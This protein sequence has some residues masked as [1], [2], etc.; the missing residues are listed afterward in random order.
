M[1]RSPT[2]SPRPRAPAGR[3]RC[4][5]GCGE[6]IRAA[7]ASD[8][9][10]Q[11]AGREE[12]EG[13]LRQ[14]D[15]QVKDLKAQEAGLLRDRRK[16]KDEKEDLERQKERMR[17]EIR[18][19]ERADA[20]QRARQRAEEILRRAYESYQEQLRR[21]EEDHGTQTRQL[22]D[23]LKRVRAQL[24]EAQ[25]KSATGSRQ[26]EGLARQDLFGEETPAPLPRRPD[27]GDPGGQARA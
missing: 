4:A 7:F 9:E 6:E 15:S 8:L 1:R 10:A 24:E 16:L 20:E 22:E 3:P 26:Q 25:H 5:S 2:S 18:R 23:Q 19:K 27:Q 13:R 17:D 21:K 14:R 12:L 11:R